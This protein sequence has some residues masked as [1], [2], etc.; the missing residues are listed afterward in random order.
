MAV[1]Y[2]RGSDEAAD[3]AA[4]VATIPV[5][6]FKSALTT[7]V[8]HIAHR[9]TKPSKDGPLAAFAMDIID[10]NGDQKIS[11]AEFQYGLGALPLAGCW[12]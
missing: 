6:I 8:D 4:Q 3:P 9:V 12:R 10:V 11:L 7:H 5:G 1:S 2:D